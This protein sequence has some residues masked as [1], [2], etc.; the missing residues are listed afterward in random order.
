[1]F[2]Y[3]VSLSHLVALTSALALSHSPAKREGYSP[4][5]D[6]IM[7]TDPST[8]KSYPASVLP[9]GA[10]NNNNDSNNS[11]GE[12]DGP[13]IVA[14]WWTCTL[15]AQFTYG[16][17]Y[18]DRG[19][20]G[21]GIFITNG[22]RGPG[23]RGFYVYHNGCDSVPYKYI[24][25]AAG[26]TQFLALPPLFEGR[27]TRGVDAWNLHAPPQTIATWLELALDARGWAWGDVSL[28]RGCDGG[29][30]LWAVDGR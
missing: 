18:D 21:P 1:M 4:D 3:I 28:I 24:W 5:I 12:T 29:A 7:S 2:R 25:V 30:V 26:A 15:Q 20:G 10:S 17:N 8:F 14:H 13:E 23:Y 6:E 16:D 27:V 22:D 11:N 19:A 9:R